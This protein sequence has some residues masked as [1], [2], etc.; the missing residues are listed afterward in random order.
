[1]ALTFHFR[2]KSMNINQYDDITSRLEKAGF[3]NPKGR[4]YH[5]CFGDK[6]TLQVLDVWDSQENF[7]KFGETLMPLLSQVKVDPGT[8]EVSKVH[9][10]INGNQL[11]QQNTTIAKGIYNAFNSH[12]FVSGEKLI[13]DTAEL[14][15]VPFNMTLLGKPGY[16]QL[17][18]GWANA[19]PDGYCDVTNIIA[20][21]EGYVAEFVGRGRHTGPLVSPEGQ[22]MPTGRRVDV[23]FVEIVKI[24]NGKIV[25]LKE[26]FDISTMMKQL[27]LVPELKH[28]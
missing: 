6:D 17:S 25:S 14:T 28:Q 23:P 24:R 3:G 27:G 12:D 18:Q 13:D 16:N 5:L 2:P 9:N 26:Y 11:V 10:I 19:F 21:E 1:M 4:I 7:N 15:I 22:I 20:S 8:P